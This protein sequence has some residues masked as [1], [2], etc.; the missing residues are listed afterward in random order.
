MCVLS[1]SKV[2]VNLKHYAAVYKYRNVFRFFFVYCKQCMLR[3][4]A[5]NY[6]CC[7]FPPPCQSVTTQLIRTT[8]SVVLIEFQW[9]TRAAFVFADVLVCVQKQL[10]VLMKLD[11]APPLQEGTMHAY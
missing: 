7:T 3:V 2:V 8:H 1:G 6:Q 5:E 9:V 11:A 4:A 10:I